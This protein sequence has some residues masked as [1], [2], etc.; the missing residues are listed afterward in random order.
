MTTA[1]AIPRR[2]HPAASRQATATEIAA[3]VRAGEVTPE[4]VVAAALARIEAEN[5]H[6][7]AVDVVRPEALDEA[8]HVEPALPLAGVPVLVKAEFDIAGL[9][10]TY[11]GRAHTTPAARDSEVVRRLRAAGA[12][13]LG[14][15][16]LPEFG[17]F[18]FTEGDSYGVTRNP[19]SPH[20]TPGGSSGGSAAAVAAGLVPLAIGGDGGGSVRIPAACC[21]LVGLK[22]RRGR[23]STAPNADLWGVLGTIGP[24]TRTVADTALAYEVLQG[25]L[26]SDRFDAHRL[27]FRAA[28][29]REPGRLR[30]GL[31]TR[32]A[33]PLRAEPEVVAA[34]ETTA[35][36]LKQAGHDVREL[37]GRW[38]SDQPAYGVLFA[39]ALAAL[40]SQVDHPERLEARTRHTAALGAVLPRRV[41]RAAEQAGRRL[42]R[43]VTQRFAGVDVVL[44][45]TLC[46]LPPRSPQLLGHGS[47]LS[48]LRA[49]PM[50][51][52]TTLANV[53]GHAA[54]SFPAAMSRDGLPIG[55]QLYAPRGD[56]SV[57]VSLA[58]Q[59]E[60]LTPHRDAVP[61]AEA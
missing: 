54:L 21:G 24:L 30:I 5:P 2:P 32:P 14:T 56:E 27:D 1:A 38:P 59:L 61:S 15:T 50:A 29:A 33:P 55:V 31:L 46:V 45:P 16:H 40:R 34:A 20:H 18:P 41:V 47:A 19:W 58:A 9:V 28:A 42:A 4:E 13:I 6:L 11:G 25:S 52:F 35:H 23:I 49:L 37:P 3:A 10:T 53:T 44:S 43:E 39:D 26:P 17:Q 12:I 60:R 22:P 7:N 8:R 36:L 48:L 51:A 57:L